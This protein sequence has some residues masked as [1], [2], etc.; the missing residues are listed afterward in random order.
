MQELR[1]VCANFIS[2]DVNALNRYAFK[3]CRKRMHYLHISFYDSL[4][5]KQRGNSRTV[6]RNAC[7]YLGGMIK[8]V[9][10]Y[11]QDGTL[12]GMRK[13]QTGNKGLYLGR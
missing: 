8:L 13:A 2:A 11:K 4:Y 1:R 10:E 3:D 9:T 12:Y 7:V 6:K 5:Q